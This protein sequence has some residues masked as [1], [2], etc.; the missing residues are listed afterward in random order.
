[1]L[2]RHRRAPL[3]IGSPPEGFEL[4]IPYAAALEFGA[5]AA[6]LRAIEATTRDVMALAAVSAA[7]Q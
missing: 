7:P 3:A 4:I 5:P 2:E 6:H 1:M